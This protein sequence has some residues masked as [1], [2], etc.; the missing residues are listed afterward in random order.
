MKSHHQVVVFSAPLVFLWE[1]IPASPVRFSESDC[2]PV[3][4][5]IFC[6]QIS[7]LCRMLWPPLPQPLD[8]HFVT[9]YVYTYICIYVYIFNMCMCVYYV[10]MH[11]CICVY[12]YV[13]A[14]IYV[15]MCTCIHVYND[16]DVYVY[17]YWERER[18]TDFSM[19]GWTIEKMSLSQQTRTHA[20]SCVC[21]VNMSSKSPIYLE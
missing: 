2:K 21:V 16:Y 11:I 3:R 18:Q 10:C 7:T 13:C 14:C 17:V 1:K 19:I 9:L 6:S 8:L 5:L 20:L 12:M 4:H 15:Y